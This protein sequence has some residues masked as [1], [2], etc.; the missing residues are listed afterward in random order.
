MSDNDKVIKRAKDIMAFIT[1]T[2]E[3]DE[4]IDYSALLVVL[5]QFQF[6]DNAL[7]GPMERCIENLVTDMNNFLEHRYNEMLILSN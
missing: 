3:E 5:A 7:D 4:N 2:C 1:L 6:D